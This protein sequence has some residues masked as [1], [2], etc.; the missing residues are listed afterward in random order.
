MPSGPQVPSLLVENLHIHEAAYGVYHPNFDRHVYRNVVIRRT[1]TEP[2]NRGHD[3]L[4]AQHGTLVVDGLT[5]VDC[6]SGDMP[7]VQ[8]S[9]DNPTGARSRTCGT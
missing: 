6:R 4:S 9:D 3:D 8:I 2:F 1:N 7:L 5:F